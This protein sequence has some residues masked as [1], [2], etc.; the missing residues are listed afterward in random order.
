MFEE[1]SKNFARFLVS[2]SHKILRSEILLTSPSIT[3]GEGWGPCTEHGP[4]RLFSFVAQNFS[5][6]HFKLVLPS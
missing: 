5:I 2:I 3:P 4:A 1:G 6:D